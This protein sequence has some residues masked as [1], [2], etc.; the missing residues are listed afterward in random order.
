MTPRYHVN[1]CLIIASC[2]LML[3]T[4]EERSRLGDMTRRYLSLLAFA[5]LAYVAVSTLT[6]WR[7][8]S[9]YIERTRGV[10]EA[11]SLPASH[12]A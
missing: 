1:S 7:M 8:Y 6:L 3:V 2:V 4:G 12:P 11:I 5:G 10:P 9:L